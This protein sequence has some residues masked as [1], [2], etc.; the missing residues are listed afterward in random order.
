[1]KINNI[2]VHCGPEAL[3][4]H[5]ARFAESVATQ[6]AKDHTTILLHLDRSL[7]RETQGESLVAFLVRGTLPD[8]G[9]SAMVTSAPDG[10]YLEMSLGQDAGDLEALCRCLHTRRVAG[11]HYVWQEKLSQLVLALAGHY[12]PHTS[13]LSL[14][15]SVGSSLIDPW[16]QTILAFGESHQASLK[17]D[18]DYPYDGDEDVRWISCLMGADGSWALKLLEEQTVEHVTS[19]DADRIAAIVKKEELKVVRVERLVLE[20]RMR[21]LA[22]PI[23]LKVKYAGSWHCTLDFG[24]HVMFAEGDAPQEVADKIVEMIPAAWEQFVLGNASALPPGGFAV[25]SKLREMFREV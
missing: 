8:G 12:A 18:W 19:Y 4:R 10:D 16:S 25:R 7:P 21:H 2:T 5:A 24:E 13:V 23:F 11:D 15:W 22:S 6:L 1:M 3:P 20:G 14:V 9:V 17:G